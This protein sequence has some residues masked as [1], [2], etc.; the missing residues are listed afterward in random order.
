MQL[1]GSP[2]THERFNRR[3]LGSYGPAI[4]AGKG[5]FPGQTTPIP[6][7]LRC[8]DNVNPGI[9]V[10]AVASSGAMAAVAI[11]TVDQH[12]EILNKIRI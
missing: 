2:L 7:L 10:P 5:S 4:A 12:I 1:V 3:H 8:G 11:L 9:G 6:G